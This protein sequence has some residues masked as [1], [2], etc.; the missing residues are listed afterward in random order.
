MGGP[1]G[2]WAA[3]PVLWLVWRRSLRRLR[4][5]IESGQLP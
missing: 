2:A 4:W 5:L 3:T 1:F